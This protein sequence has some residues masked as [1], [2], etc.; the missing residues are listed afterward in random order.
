VDEDGPTDSQV[1]P[2][3]PPQPEGTP[4]DQAE[5]GDPGP[6]E[7]MPL[8]HSED[9][10]GDPGPIETVPLMRTLT[11]DEVET[12]EQAAPSRSEDHEESGDD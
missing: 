7:T 3:S 8:I 10:P 12:A 6:I 11:K 9:E 4:A 1:E 2:S 5:P